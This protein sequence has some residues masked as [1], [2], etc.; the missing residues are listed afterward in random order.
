M[1]T[2]WILLINDWNHNLANL[3]KGQIDS[4]ESNKHQVWHHLLRSYLT[5]IERIIK[6]FKFLTKNVQAY[7]ELVGQ[8]VKK[9]SA[10]FFFKKNPKTQKI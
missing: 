3:L 8:A 4:M 6:T 1:F 7:F 10:T 5:S 9:P 2:S